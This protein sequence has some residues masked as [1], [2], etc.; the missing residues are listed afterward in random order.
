MT[1]STPTS[2]PTLTL[3]LAPHCYRSTYCLRTDKTPC[4]Y[5]FGYPGPVH[6]TSCR[7]A[8]EPTLSL[9]PYCHRTDKLRADLPTDTL[10][11]SLAPYCTR[12]DKTPR[13]YA[14]GPR[15]CAGTVLPHDTTIST[16]PYLTRP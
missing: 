16:A 1:T 14:Y 6:Q 11:L 3:T 10:T 7:Y 5:A 4:R 13:R 8:Y 12:T 15:P 9:A 2:T